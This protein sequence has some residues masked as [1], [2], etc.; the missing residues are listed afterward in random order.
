MTRANKLNPGR[1]ELKCWRIWRK[2]RSWQK[3]WFWR[4]V[5]KVVDE[6]IRANKLTQLKGPHNV[7]DNGEFGESRDFSKILPSTKVVGEI[8]RANK[9]NPAR[10]AP[11]CWRIWQ[12]RRIWQKWRFWR[13]FANVAMLTKLWLQKKLV[14]NTY[15]LPGRAPESWWIHFKGTHK[16]YWQKPQTCYYVEN[17]ISRS[18][19]Q[20]TV[21]H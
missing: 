21:T 14:L 9:L 17:I 3:W 2:R 13:N 18:G 4:N 16:V 6:M 15:D 12:K 19:V 11:K 20:L 1:R 10:R 8:I 7:G 5:A